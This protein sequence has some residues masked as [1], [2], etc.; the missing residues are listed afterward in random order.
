MGFYV[1][2]YQYDWKPVKGGFT[3]PPCICPRCQNSVVSVLCS[4][5]DGVGFPG[6]WTYKYNKVYAFKCPICPNFEEI[7]AELAKAI[8]KGG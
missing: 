4:D 1:S 5:G 6:L 8:I 3:K 2:R 7:S